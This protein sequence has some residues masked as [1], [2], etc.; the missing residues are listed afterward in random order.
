[1]PK[2]L[3]PHVTVFCDIH[4]HCD[5]GAYA[6]GT[7]EHDETHRTGLHIVVGRLHHE[8]PPVPRRGGRR[9]QALPRQH[10]RRYSAGYR[11]RNFDFPPEW[12]DRVTAEYYGMKKST[13][14]GHATTTGAIRE[15]DTER[16]VLGRRQLPGTAAHRRDTS[17]AG[18]RNYSATTTRE[19]AAR[20]SSAK[21]RRTKK[22]PPEKSSDRRDDNDEP[23]YSERP[24]M[25]ASQQTI[26]SSPLKP[27]LP[28]ARA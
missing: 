9:R 21:R 14:S 28:T 16:R 27:Q 26:R 24:Q 19:I 1:M 2:D 22:Q 4:S 8:P 12:M 6:S 23:N 17:R 10:R 11:E 25:I 13:T 18:C 3:P 15:V 7:D 20:R 5:M